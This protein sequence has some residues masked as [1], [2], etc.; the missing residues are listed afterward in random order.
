MS[1]TE[2]TNGISRRAVLAGAATIG[3]TTSKL[4]QYWGVSFDEKEWLEDAMTDCGFRGN[5]D[6][7]KRYLA[8]NGEAVDWYVGHFEGKTEEE[9]GFKLVP[10]EYLRDRGIEKAGRRHTRPHTLDR[11]IGVIEWRDG[12]VLDIVRQ[13]LDRK[14]MGINNARVNITEGP[15]GPN[16]VKVT[17]ID[18]CP[19]IAP[20]D[21]EK[22]I[23]EIIEAL[24]LP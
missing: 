24:K 12:T 20:A 13:P 14:G 9:L 21:V 15:A 10:I 16:V 11:I 5:I 6:L 17:C 2:A 23:H 3:G 18:D 1:S 22:M 4:H 19:Y 8:C 7:Y